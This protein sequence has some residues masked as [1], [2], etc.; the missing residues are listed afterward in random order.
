MLSKSTWKIKN[1][2]WGKTGQKYI[3][4]SIVEE[5]QQGAPLLLCGLN[6]CSDWARNEEMIDWI[7]YQGLKIIEAWK[8]AGAI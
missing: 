5:E 4:N 1:S 7:A 3:Y 8:A 6:E 2:P